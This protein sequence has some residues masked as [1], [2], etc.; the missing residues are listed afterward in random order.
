M[1]KLSCYFLMLLMAASVLGACDKKGVGDLLDVVGD[2]LLPTGDDDTGAVTSVVGIW[3]L[4]TK[5]GYIATGNSG[6]DVTLTTVA[7]SLMPVPVPAGLSFDAS[8]SYNY[9]VE[10][11]TDENL[12]AGTY[13]FNKDA[14]KLVLTPGE[15]SPLAAET[16]D[17]L[18]ADGKQLKL[19]K[20]IMNVW[21]E[22]LSTVLSAYSQY[23]P[24][25]ATVTLYFDV[26]KSPE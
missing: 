8:G 2:V 1:K 25:R 23:T 9:V 20:S 12:Y 10:D 6:T 22:L 16:Y 19:Q 5:S 3:Q 14:K 13:S 21:A 17:V 11:E 7:F 4:M 24:K 18:I 26:Y 15:G